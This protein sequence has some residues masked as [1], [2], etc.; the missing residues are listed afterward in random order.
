MAAQPLP[1]PPTG[2]GDRSATPDGVTWWGHATT[3]IHLAGASLLTDPLLRPGIGPLRWAHARPPH[4]LVRQVSAVLLSHLHHDHLDLPSLATVPA[5]VP[6][7]VPAGG[8]RYLSRHLRAEIVEVGRG[9]EVQLGSLTVRAVHAEHD[10]RRWPLG[11]AVPALGYLVS[12]PAGPPG[13]SGRSGRRTVYFAGDT[14]LYPQMA[15][16][17]RYD[18]ALAL[19]PV[20][21][22]GV[23]LGEGHLNARRAAQALQLLRPA[24]AIPIHWGGLRVPVLWR[25]RPHLF[26]TPGVE[27]AEHAAELAPAV[28]VTVSRLGER[29]DLP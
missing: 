27:F 20:G 9:D 24:A 26:H 3:V 13:A 17:A 29:V 4:G 15:D 16:L 6:V 2:I 11:P 14:D 19:L 22:W 5:G 21:G 1:T 25:S 23:T 7:L 18:L 12:G 28:R 8:A 10:G